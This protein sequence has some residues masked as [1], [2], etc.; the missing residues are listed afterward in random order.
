MATP[1]DQWYQTLSSRRVDLVGDY[2]GTELFLIDG[3]SLLLQAFS[4]PLL[5]FQGDSFQLFH[6]VYTVE[7]FLK[8]LLDRRC[9]FEVV[10]FDDHEFLSIPARINETDKWKFIVARPAIIRHLQKN[11]VETVPICQYPSILSPGFLQYL[12]NIGIYF[13]MAHDGARCDDHAKRIIRFSLRWF[14]SQGWNIALMNT[15]DFQ[16]TKVNREH[17][18]Y[19]FYLSTIGY[20]HSAGRSSTPFFDIFSLT[21]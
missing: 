5:D 20:Q 8:K 9:R 3:N 17:V 19:S 12:Q 11:L 6:A 21:S 14:V 16:D 18:E 1:L 4:D 15:V 13:V 10:F 7:L 2:A